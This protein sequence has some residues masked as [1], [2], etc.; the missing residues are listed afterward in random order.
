MKDLLLFAVLVIGA[1]AAAKLT[2][3][4]N[5]FTFGENRMRREK[6]GNSAK[7]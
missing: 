5:H 6:N 3:W 2:K 4:V 1:I 7:E